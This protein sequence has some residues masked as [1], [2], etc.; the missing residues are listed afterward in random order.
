LSADPRIQVSPAGFLEI[1]LCARTIKERS[2]AAGGF[3][4]HPNGSYRPDSTAWA[5]LALARLDPKSPLLNPARARLQAGQLEDGRLSFPKASSA[6][7]PTPLA[8]LAWH[9]SGQYRE[10]ESRSVT[11]ML[12]TTG[13]YGKRDPNSPVAHDPSIKGWPWTD[14]T[15]SFVDPTS[16]TLIALEMAG[17]SGHLR[18]Q[19]GLR[20]LVDRQLPRGGWNYGNTLV[21]GKELYPFIDTTGMALTAVAGH[22]SRENV[23]KSILLLNTQVETCRT[24]LSLC[25]ALFGLGAWGE[26]PPQANI[27]INEALQRQEKYGAYTT[28]LLSHLLLAFLCQG[29][30]RKCVLQ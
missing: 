11:F 15:H 23:Q 1:D 28:S 20:M 16:L 14:G 22:V 21:Y 8:V 4:E 26:L 12:K 7:W 13:T 9:S 25:W 5:A 3:S 10:A 30:F 19:E 24:P 18:F 27:W 17:F 6:F 2:L 29:N